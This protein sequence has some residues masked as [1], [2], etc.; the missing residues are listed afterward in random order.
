MEPLLAGESQRPVKHFCLA[1]D[2]QKGFCTPPPHLSAPSCPPFMS[3]RSRLS[4]TL[5]V[6]VAGCGSMFYEGW[7]CAQCSPAAPP[8]APPAW[9][10][11]GVPWS[12]SLITLVG[13][14]RE[15]PGDCARGSHLSGFWESRD[16]KKVGFLAGFF[17]PIWGPKGN[18]LS[19]LSGSGCCLGL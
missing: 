2:T 17:L 12:R 14:G 10:L 16:V 4:S 15:R 7:G 19:R 11:G 6:S 13:G 3:R 5:M 8:E 18:P 9:L 1:M